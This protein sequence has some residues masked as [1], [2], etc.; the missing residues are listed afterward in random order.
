MTIRHLIALL[1]LKMGFR[2]LF[3]TSS[4]VRFDFKLY[5]TLVSIEV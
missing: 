5:P 4:Q 2:A 1:D 3:M